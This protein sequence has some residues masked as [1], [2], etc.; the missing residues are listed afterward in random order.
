MIDRATVEKEFMEF[1]D[2]HD[3]SWAAVGKVQPLAI[4]QIYY[5]LADV[6]SGGKTLTSERLPLNAP[7]DSEFLQAANGKDSAAVFA[8]MDDLMDTI[9]VTAPR[10]YSSVMRRI[11]EIDA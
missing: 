1:V 10:A 6:V 9:R 11:K 3:V 7:G 2:S 4:M 8:I 5:M